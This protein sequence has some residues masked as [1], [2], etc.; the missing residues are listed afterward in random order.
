MKQLPW[1]LVRVIVMVGMYACVRGLELSWLNCHRCLPLRPKT[2]AMSLVDVAHVH[3]HVRM[4]ACVEAGTILDEFSGNM[5]LVVFGSRLPGRFRIGSE[6]NND[7]YKSI[8]AEVVTLSL[9][10]V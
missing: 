6:S 2:F 4:Y 7:R 8:Y 1:R 9:V 3:A 5:A 10:L